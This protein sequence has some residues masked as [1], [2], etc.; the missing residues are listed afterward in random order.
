MIIERVVG[1]LPFFIVTTEG[2][3][4]RPFEVFQSASEKF[5][6]RFGNSK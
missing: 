1:R 6:H 5:E 2:K 3:F 4:F